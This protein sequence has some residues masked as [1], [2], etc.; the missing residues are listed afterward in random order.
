M[1][2]HNMAGGFDG[3]EVTHAISTRREPPTA[4]ASVM[5]VK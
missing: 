2:N 4:Q 1:H 5:E 3:M